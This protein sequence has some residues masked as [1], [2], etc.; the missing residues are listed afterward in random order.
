[1]RE[2]NSRLQRLGGVMPKIGGKVLVVRDI[3]NRPNQFI[4]MEG[5]VIDIT[6]I[7]NEPIISVDLGNTVEEF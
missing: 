1:M 7:I 4:G 6:H 3:F 5:S 2:R